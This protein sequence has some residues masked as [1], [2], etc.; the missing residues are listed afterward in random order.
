M[1]YQDNLLVFQLLSLGS[2]VEKSLHHA[3]SVQQ[4]VSEELQ[5]DRTWKNTGTS[6]SRLTHEFSGYT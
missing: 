2:L 4:L 5:E 1:C 3:N 6:L